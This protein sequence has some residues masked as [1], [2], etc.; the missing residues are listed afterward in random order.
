MEADWDVMFAESGS[1]P[2]NK[3]AMMHRDDDGQRWSSLESLIQSSRKGREC[4][5]HGC[6]ALREAGRLL[7]KIS[8][9]TD[10]LYPFVS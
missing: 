8:S 4:N 2:L 1:T 3:P 9:E 10:S 6:E 7:E 5:S